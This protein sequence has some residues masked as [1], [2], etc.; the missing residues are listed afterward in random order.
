MGGPALRNQDKYPEKVDLMLR[1]KN[2][3]TGGEVRGY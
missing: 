3:M 2:M 1:P